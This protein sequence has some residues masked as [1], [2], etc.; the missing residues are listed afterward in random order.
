MKRVLIT[1]A[2]AVLLTMAVGVA[3][4]YG[5][6]PI[7]P[8][9]TGTE[10]TY[11]GASAPA[12]VPVTSPGQ[13]QA[14]AQSNTAQNDQLSL[15]GEAQNV[16]TGLNNN[17][18]QVGEAPRD[19]GVITTSTTPA[20]DNGGNES[21][22]NTN[23]VGDQTAVN[24]NN[25]QQSNDTQRSGGACCEK[26]DSHSQPA[27]QQ[28]S[29]HSEQGAIVVGGTNVQTGLNNN[30]V[31]VGSHNESNNNTNTAGDQTAVNGNNLQQS[32]ESTSSSKKD[33]WKGGEPKR[34]GCNSKCEPRKPTYDKKCSCVDHSSGNESNG[35]TNTVGDQ[36]A[37]NGNN[38][39]Q[40]NTGSGG[41]QN[42]ARNEQ[43]SI[44]AGVA[45]IQTGLNNNTVQLGGIGKAPAPPPVAGF[46]RTPTNG[47][48]NGGIESNHNTNTVGDQTAVNGNNFQQSNAGSG[49]QQNSARNEQLSFVLGATNVQTGLNNNTV[50][51]GQTQRVIAE[52]LTRSPS[53]G[54]GGNESNGNTNT[55]GDQTAVNGNNFQQSNEGTAS[56]GY[57]KSRR[58]SGGQS[59]Y[60]KSHQGAI[61]IG[62]TNI[63]TGLN[64][65]TVQLGGHNESNGNTNTV[66]DQTA[67]NGN[68]FQQ[69]NE[70]NGSSNYGSWKGGEPKG[71]YSR[72]EQQQPKCY[73]RCEP[74]RCEPNPC[75]KRDYGKPGYHK[76]DGRTPEQADQSNRASNKQGSIVIGGL[77]VQTGLNNNT[78]QLGGHNESNGNTNTV[79]DQT[80]VN[81]NNFQQS[82][83]SN[84]SDGGQSN[85]AYGRKGG[86]YG[87]SKCESKCDSRCE[88]KCDGHDGNKQGAIVIGGVNVQTGLNNNTVQIGG[89]NE[90]NH[91]TNT[92]GDQTAVN[93]NNFQQ[94]NESN[95][96]S[97][98]GSW[99]GGEPKHDSCYDRC[100]QPKCYDRCEEQQPKCYDRC[101]PKP[102]KP[103]PCDKPEYGKPEHADQSNQASNKQGSIVIGGLNVQTGLN[104][105]TVQ[106][107]G[108]NESNHNTNTVGDQ[109]AVNGN[110]FQQSN[111]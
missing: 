104:N 47:G 27:G 69:S 71:C 87:S 83:E 72:C 24:G 99:N 32:N 90:S 101:E 36:T 93:G 46:G 65:N 66:G 79:G 49:G 102:C 56:N 61:V 58:S 98:N 82:N 16:Q 52:S 28:N 20:V 3:T 110:N 107:G 43:G 8:P 1:L 100:E 78:V 7:A 55:A 54:G 53:Y 9:T 14:P 111:A 63:Q 37:V 29:A 15:V 17:T 19:G 88:Y 22:G 74:K 13:S 86:D 105:N 96:S 85:T 94:S 26:S 50:Q 34:Y 57:W 62:G 30:T 4:A 77:N 80:A 35:N 33:S 40:S 51:L 60:A 42:Q 68:N 18:V 108:D 44:V 6:G 95:G 75:D 48:G 2:A 76:P 84:G 103:N 23:T 31:Q 109:T 41:Q 25:A 5:G 59:N 70:S 10:N 97:N 21:N 106:V 38:F 45:N 73:D 11:Q 81:G 12:S 91:N 92:A 64:N 39:Q 89:H 67:V